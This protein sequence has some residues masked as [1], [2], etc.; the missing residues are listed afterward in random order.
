MH[1]NQSVPQMCLPQAQMPH[2]NI[3]PLPIKI[4]VSQF[5]YE[6]TANPDKIV[7]DGKVTRTS[8]DSNVITVAAFLKAYLTMKKPNHLLDLIQFHWKQDSADG[9]DSSGKKGRG[10]GGG[11]GNAAGIGIVDIKFGDTI[12]NFTV[13][14]RDEDSNNSNSGSSSK[15]SELV[16]GLFLQEGDAGYPSSLDPTGKMIA[17]CRM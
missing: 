6:L 14:V 11:S 9:T 1:M 2:M 8:V 3:L 17:T 12:N 7:L 4:K 10:G 16:L 15:K 5:P 13:I